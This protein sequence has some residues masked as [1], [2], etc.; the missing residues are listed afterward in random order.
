MVRSLH[1]QVEQVR[2]GDDEVQVLVVDLR[3]MLR[4][5]CL[6]YLGTKVFEERARYAGE[7]VQVRW[8]VEAAREVGCDGL[9]V[10][11]RGLDKIYDWNLYMSA[12]LAVGRGRARTSGIICRVVPMFRCIVT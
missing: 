5:V 1:V 3:Q 2:F 12:S 10:L 6:D 11:R 7:E 4:R 9:E 8:A